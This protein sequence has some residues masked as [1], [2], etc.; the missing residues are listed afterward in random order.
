MRSRWAEAGYPAYPVWIP[1]VMDG[2]AIAAAVGCAIQRVGEHP[3][4][5]V[6][7]LV[8]VALTPW[9]VGFAGIRLSWPVFT[10][11]VLGGTIA[12]MVLYPV[13]YDFAMYL[14]ILMAGHVGATDTVLGSAVATAA[15]GVSL[16]VLQL[17]GELDG[18]GFW[19][20][21]L[22]VGWDVGYMMQH[23]QRALEEQLRTQAS[24]EKQVALEERQRIAREVHDVIAHSLSVT[25]LHLT[26]ARRDLE[27]DGAD[28]GEAIDA[29]R[30]AERLGRQAM[31]DIRRTVGLLGSPGPGPVAPAPDLGEVPA[32]VEEFR[33]AGLDVVLDCSVTGEEL[34][35]PVGLGIY[36][37]LQES[38]T[39]VAK[40]QPRARV[41][42]ALLPVGATLQLT[43]RNDLGGAPAREPDGL[44]SGLRGMRERA[45][46]LGGTLSAGPVGPDGAAWQVHLEVPLAGPA[47]PETHASSRCM[48]FGLPRRPLE[49]L[50]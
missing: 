7:A 27:E 6:T 49:E 19:V 36:R 8:L 33:G 14:L 46:L 42:V 13:E 48:P 5:P 18:A 45:E 41:E 17:L 39:N 37:I 35:A 11:L 12:L 1:I 29:L 4:L 38:L 26:A 22:V 24:R 47:A 28:V 32:L 9:L 30:D 3:M 23:Q 44:G 16:V 15:A 2:A 43:V 21:A 34:P 10:A 50:S 31:S 20:A 40:H 25:M